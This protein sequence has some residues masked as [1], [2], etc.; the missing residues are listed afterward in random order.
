MGY[1][2]SSAV[3]EQQQQQQQQQQNTKGLATQL[4]N[5]HRALGQQ[6]ETA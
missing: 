3:S 2:G 6:Q 4:V 5:H 1:V